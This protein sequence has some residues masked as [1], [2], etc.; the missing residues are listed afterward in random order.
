M[1]EIKFRG[2]G[3]DE[4]KREWIYG[5]LL[6]EKAVDIVAIQD[7]NCHVWEVEPDSVGQFTGFEDFNGVDIYEDDIL[8]AKGV[9]KPIAM[10]SWNEFSGAWG[11]L[12]DDGYNN[13]TK[14]NID[15]MKLRVV[16]ARFVPM[17]KDKSEES[18]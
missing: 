4:K 16:G 13:L 6:V 14:H 18:I 5:S 8:V 17:L 9:Y 7:E 15:M 11:L 3:K 2:F 1:R 10:V 12:F